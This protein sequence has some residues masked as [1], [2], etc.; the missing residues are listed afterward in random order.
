MADDTD[1]VE[2]YHELG[3][4]ADCS[5]TDFKNAFRR[6]LRDL[7]PDRAPNAHPDDVEELQRLNRLYHSAMSFRRRHGR[8]PGAPIAKATRSASRQVG[9]V[10][11]L[12]AAGTGSAGWWVFLL[13]LLIAITWYAA[14]RDPGDRHRPENPDTIGSLE[15]GHAT[16]RLAT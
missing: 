3:I 12:H 7:H 1:F 14:S 11:H 8:M 2:L 4:D 9:R 10:P 5:V 15:A 16:G 13:L 6:R